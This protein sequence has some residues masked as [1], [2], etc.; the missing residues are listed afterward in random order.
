LKLTPSELQALG[1]PVIRQRV[2]FP[3]SDYESGPR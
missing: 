3:G 2:A 1:V